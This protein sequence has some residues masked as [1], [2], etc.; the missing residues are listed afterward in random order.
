MTLPLTEWRELG[1]SGRR[2]VGAAARR[3]Q[4]HPDP[5]VAHL[6][7]AWASE[8]LRVDRLSLPR[9]E[10][11]AEAGLGPVLLATIGAL[12][13]SAAIGAS[14]G[15]GLSRRERRLARRIVALGPPAARSGRR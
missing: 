14:L 10:R 5:Y 4:T 2:E 3:G 7:H 9:R 1:T 8:V 6:A 13:E 15:T 12:L 11:I